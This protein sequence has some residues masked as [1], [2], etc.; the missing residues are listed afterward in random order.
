MQRE[1]GFAAVYVTHD[2]AEAMELAH[3]IAVM[4]E[5]R[6]SQVGPPQDDLH[7]AGVAVRRELRRLVERARGH[8]HSRRRAASPSSRRTIGA[9]R[10]VAAEGVA[11][12]EPARRDLPARAHCGSRRSEPESPNRWRAEVRASAFLGAEHRAR[13]RRR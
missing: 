8:G 6:S 1:L 2:Q 7:R 5:G 9:V 13:R 3:R 10:G 4:R 12:G 11:A